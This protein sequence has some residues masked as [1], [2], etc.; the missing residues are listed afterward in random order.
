V[1]K[2]GRKTAVVR[3]FEIR[4]RVEA[5]VEQGYAMDLKPPPAFSSGS[6]GSSS[7]ELARARAGAPEPSTETPFGAHSFT[8]ARG[9]D[10]R[11]TRA[12]LDE[13]LAGGVPKDIVLMLEADLRP[14]HN[15]KAFREEVL[16]RFP[17]PADRKALLRALEVAERAHEGQTQT[18]K[19]EAGGLS[20]IPYVNH[21]IQVA[22]LAMSELGLSA[23][24]VQAA[25]LHDVVED[26]KVGLRELSAEFSP[27][28]LD[29]V[30]DLTKRKDEERAVYLERVSKLE[31]D[32]AA[33]KG[34]DRVHNLLRA[35]TTRDPDYLD[36]YIRE[37]H[38]VY[39]P[40]F[41]KEPLSALEPLFTHLLSSLEAYRDALR[42]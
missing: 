10:E 40:K 41:R 3:P 42:E 12:L 8:A 15:A 36:R 11:K 32:A 17:D 27:P 16:R 25:L 21:S 5:R 39:A 20:H 14:E 34:L 23:S 7:A 37:S 1:T 26:T 6:N 24:S 33:L 13:L 29:V 2:V 35:F 4:S 19:S 9:A 31:G 28:V 38:G 30:R 18:R 22:R